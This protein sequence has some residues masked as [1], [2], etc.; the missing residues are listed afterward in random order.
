MKEVFGNIEPGAIYPEDEYNNIGRLLW[1][2]GNQYLFVKGGTGGVQKGAGVVVDTSFVATAA[3][4]GFE[5]NA[6]ATMDIP[7]DYYGLVMT[8]SDNATVNTTESTAQANSTGIPDGTTGKNGKVKAYANAFTAATEGS[9]TDAELQG[10]ADEV[11]K[12]ASN[13]HVILNG[14][15][16][17]SSTEDLRDLINNAAFTGSVSATTS[18]AVS[19]PNALLPV[20]LQVGDDVLINGTDGGAITAISASGGTTTIT[21]TNSITASGAIQRKLNQVSCR[22]V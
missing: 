11:A 15:P 7:A 4:S 9:P 6:V 1:L 8:K 19:D 21:F 10:L 20:M 2:N 13:S 3:S 12:V 16:A 18:V 17:A 14:T 22:L 5:V